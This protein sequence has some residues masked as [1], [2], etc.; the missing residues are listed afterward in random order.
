MGDLKRD[1]RSVGHIGYQ[2]GSVEVRD[3]GPQHLASGVQ[4]GDAQYEKII[5]EMEAA[6][7][8]LRPLLADYPSAL[9]RWAETEKKTGDIYVRLCDL[10]CKGWRE[11]V[12]HEAMSETMKY[13]DH[14]A[15]TDGAWR[16]L[17]TVAKEWDEAMRAL[18][19]ITE[20]YTNYRTFVEGFGTERPGFAV[21]SILRPYANPDDG[22]KTGPKK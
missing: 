16:H 7:D 13:A 22:P 17:V 1:G 18:G 14:D 2:E 3:D 9:K 6:V 12:S 5:S 8:R 20:R 15:D 11:G 19:K 21:G 10:I 4:P